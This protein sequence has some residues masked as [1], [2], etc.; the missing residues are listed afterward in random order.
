MNVFFIPDQGVTKVAKTA[1]GQDI[2][3][4]A[5]TAS[6]QARTKGTSKDATPN[7]QRKTQPGSA[8][9][10]DEPQVLRIDGRSER[11]QKAA[12]TQMEQSNMVV[13]SLKFDEAFE[14]LFLTGEAEKSFNQSLTLKA[15][16]LVIEKN[17]CRSSLQKIER[18]P[19]NT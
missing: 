16:A 5:P 13:S 6:G 3:A 4:R 2:K 9:K 8:T 1:S 14:G 15:Q 18:S 7:A 10:G 17:N 12:Q 11:I 19:V